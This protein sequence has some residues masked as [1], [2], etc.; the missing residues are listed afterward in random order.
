MKLLLSFLIKDEFIRGESKTLKFLFCFLL[1][2]YIKRPPYV[3]KA[4]RLSFRQQEPTALTTFAENRNDFSFT[5]LIVFDSVDETLRCG[6][7]AILIFGA[8]LHVNIFP[9]EILGYFFIIFR[10]V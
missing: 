4:I 2:V 5:I 9:S 3:I 7:R 10:A 8:A 1:A 6:I